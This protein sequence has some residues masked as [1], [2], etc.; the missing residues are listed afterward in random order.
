MGL[1]DAGDKLVRE[2]SGGM[3]RRLE[4]AQSTLHRP[5]LLFLDEPTVGLDPGARRTVWEHIE[6][7]RREFGMTIFMTTHMMEEADSLCDRIVVMH[8]G[9]IS[10]IGTPA[11]LKASIGQE[12]ATLDEV[13]IHYTGDLLESGGTYRETSRSRRTA[14]RLG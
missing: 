7:L 9:R 11:E 5:P 2:Y 14:H 4:I 10:A 6:D 1:S 3:I 12:G 13:F 8:R